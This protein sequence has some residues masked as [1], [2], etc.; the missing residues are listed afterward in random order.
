TVYARGG[1][2]RLAA[3]LAAAAPAGGA[4]I[5]TG[6]EVARISSRDG[7]ATG[8]VLANGE[9]IRSRGVVSGADPK[10]TLVD[11][12]D[13]V[14]LGPSLGWRAAN[15]R[16]PGVVAKVNL[17]LKGLPTFPAAGDDQAAL[18]G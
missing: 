7:V 8:V 6:A 16:T 5:R 18:R 1:P 15:I 12:V 3:A 14:A 13:P 2:G 4:E 17:A 11:L 9:E 10:H